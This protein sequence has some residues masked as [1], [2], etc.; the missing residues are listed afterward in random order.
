MQAK[1][2]PKVIA[3]SVIRSVSQGQSHGGICL[4]DL[5]TSEISQVVDW[6]TTSINWE[7]R[8]LDRGLRG[9]AFF[10]GNAFI[11]ASDEIF[12]FDRNFNI[13]KSFR[14]TY[15]KHCHEI[16]IAGTN[17]F[18]T[19][20]GFDSV[21]IF[22]LTQESFV[23]GYCLRPSAMTGRLG[24]AVFDPE[25]PGGPLPADTIHINNV[26]YDETKLI[27]CGTGLQN[28]LYIADDKLIPGPPVPRGTHNAFLYH[29]MVLTNHTEADCI[30][31][32]DLSGRM[33]R[34]VPVPHYAESDLLMANIPKDHARQA[35]GRG[36]CVTNEAVIIGGSSP[37]TITAYNLESEKIIKSV[38]LTMDVRNSIHGLEIWPF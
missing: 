18:L 1:P 6:N 8:G 30:A 14:N 34:S 35:F 33:L 20:T 27:V 29:G 12:V 15:L 28:L 2:L 25:Q 7:G 13:V 3:T 10:Q 38:N 19:S 21:L 31:L 5:E 37:S 4:V 16:S 24:L 36:L 22:D 32:F 17:L 11:A 26:V 23:R 9:I